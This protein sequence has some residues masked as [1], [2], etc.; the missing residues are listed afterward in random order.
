MPGG[1][2]ATWP[3]PFLGVGTINVMHSVVS[4]CGAP[5]GISYSAPSMGGMSAMISRAPN[6]D[7][8]QTG[9]LANASHDGEDYLNAAVTFGTDMA[10]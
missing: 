2:N 5:T 3:S 1:V 4:C 10:G 6:M 9:G 7:A 8:D